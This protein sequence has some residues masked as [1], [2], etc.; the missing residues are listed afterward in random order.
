LLL[1]MT[2]AKHNRKDEEAGADPAASRAESQEQR[3]IQSVILTL[4][5]LGR[6]L[7]Q[8]LDTDVYYGSR[9]IAR[10]GQRIT[11]VLIQ[12]LKQLELRHLQF[13]NDEPRRLELD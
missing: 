5:L 10:R 9:R 4:A 12:K 8:S 3:H 7:G 2:D 11:P 13:T 6:N 1:D